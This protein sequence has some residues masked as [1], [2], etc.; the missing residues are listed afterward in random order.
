MNISRLFSFC[1]C[2]I[3]NLG[4]RLEKCHIYSVTIKQLAV[5]E[6]TTNRSKQHGSLCRGAHRRLT[7]SEVAMASH[8]GN[9]RSMRSPVRMSSTRRPVLGAD[10]HCLLFDSSW[11]LLG[12][13][14]RAPGPPSIIF[15]GWGARWP[16]R[17]PPQKWPGC[18]WPTQS[19][20]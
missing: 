3:L 18:R 5:H 1:V 12:V 13:G 8:S 17:R 19:E 6:N 7:S 20:C 2:V 11:G 4:A 15:Q 10:G 14:L 16:T 9:K